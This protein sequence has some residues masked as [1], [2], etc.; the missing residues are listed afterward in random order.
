MSRL[1]ENTRD[2]PYLRL[3]KSA[4]VRPDQVHHTRK[5]DDVRPS[6][7]EGGDIYI[8]IFL[9]YKLCADSEGPHVQRLRV[10]RDQLNRVIN[11]IS[12]RPSDGITLISLSHTEGIFI[13]IIS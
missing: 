7:Y 10:V 9:L 3:P 8:Y 2:S 12:D 11:G 5:V 6:Q 4:T 1:F 13:I